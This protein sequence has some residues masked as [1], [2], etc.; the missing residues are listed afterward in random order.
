[1]E[2]SFADKATAAR[3]HCDTCRNKEL[4]RCG[5]DREDFTEA[6]SNVFPMYVHQGGQQYGFCP[7]KATWDFRLAEVFRLLVITAETGVMLNG[8]GILDQ[9]AWFV[10][11]LGWFIP[12]YDTVKFME[13]ARSILGDG[14]D[15]KVN[16]PQVP[17]K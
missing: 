2:L 5:E 16:L 7:A 17:R 4:R 10:E 9:P 3:F 1:M 6:D 12:L 11:S 14:P 15:K 8:G 13:R